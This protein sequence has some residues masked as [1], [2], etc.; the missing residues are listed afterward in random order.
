MVLSALT[1]EHFIIKILAACALLASALAGPTGAFAEPKKNDGTVVKDSKVQLGPRP[2][3]LVEDMEDGPLKS[4]LQSCSTG[5]FK[6]T[7][8]SI[9]HRVAA[10]RFPELTQESNEAAAVMGAGIIECDVTFTKDRQLVCRHSQCDLHTTTNILAIPELA[11]KCTQDFVPADPDT[12]TPASAQCCSSDV[13]LAEFRSLCGQDG[14]FGSQ[15]DQR[16]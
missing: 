5:P 4:K 13:T 16:G 9:G 14:R 10:L 15:L 12:G 1:K 6:R 7:D 3:H 8:F 2:F 11:A